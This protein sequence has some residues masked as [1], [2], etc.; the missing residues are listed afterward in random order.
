MPAAEFVQFV[1]NRLADAELKQDLAEAAAAAT[2][3][4]P[5]S[6]RVELMLARAQAR[7]PDNLSHAG[8]NESRDAG[9]GG[10]A[11]RIRRQSRR[12]PGHGGY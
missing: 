9:E 10:D 12:A 6:T 8:Q 3:D 11:Q 5:V 2:Q 7:A 4:K 1:R